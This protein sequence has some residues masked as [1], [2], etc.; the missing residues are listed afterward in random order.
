MLARAC[1]LDVQRFVFIPV[2]DEAPHGFAAYSLNPFK[3]LKYTKNSPSEIVESAINRFAW[4]QKNG[5]WNGYS[6]AVQEIE[7]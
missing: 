2:E 1:G 4:C 5:I 3:K 6:D 7:A